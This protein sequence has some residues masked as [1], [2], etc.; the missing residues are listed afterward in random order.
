MN[1]K[2][3]KIN[4]MPQTIYKFQSDKSLLSEALKNVKNLTKWRQNNHNQT[5]FDYT[6]LKREEY[7]NLFKW[8]S[9]CLNFVVKDLDY[10]CDGMTVT[11]S[12]ANKSDHNQ[13]HHT[14]THSNSII[15]GIYYLTDSDCSTWFAVKNIWQFNGVICLNTMDNL[16]E[17]KCLKNSIIIHKEKSEAGKLLLFPSNLEHS[18]CTNM[19][20]EP[21]YTIS[22]N[23]FPVGELGRWDY[24][25]R[26]NL[27]PL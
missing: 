5:S 1:L 26:L 24:L 10:Q 6:L 13:W 11:Q 17:N 25:N 14:H 12:W 2:M 8:I 15:S 27:F 21:R 16:D 19:S 7:H 9:D 23:S 4:I 3:E 22:F 18:V 20:E